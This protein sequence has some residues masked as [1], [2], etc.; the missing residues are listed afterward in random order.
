[1]PLALRLIPQAVCMPQSLPILG[2]WIAGEAWHMRIGDVKDTI[3]KHIGALLRPFTNHEGHHEPPHGGNGDPHPRLA[4]GLIVEPRKRHM[5]WLGRHKA[6][7]FVEL[8]CDDME[9][10][11]Q[12]KRHCQLNAKSLTDAFLVRK[13]DWGGWRK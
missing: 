9:I 2:S 10:A 8:A 3:E 4:R 7:E 13:A 5:V 1:M 12:V 6:P 11:P